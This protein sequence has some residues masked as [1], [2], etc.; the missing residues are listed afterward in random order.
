MTNYSHKGKVLKTKDEF[1]LHHPG[2]V[3]FLGFRRYTIIGA[4]V[5]F[6][7]HEYCCTISLERNPTIVIKDPTFVWGSVL[8]WAFIASVLVASFLWRF[9]I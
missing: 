7:G 3:L 6:D 8:F 9:P 4:S 1:H 2:E 5:V